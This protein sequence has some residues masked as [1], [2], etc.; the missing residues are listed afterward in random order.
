MTDTGLPK[1][2]LVFYMQADP[3][4]LAKRG[5]Y[6]EERYEKI[7]FQK[8]VKQHF[9]EIFESQDNVE[10]INALYSEEDIYRYIKQKV[11]TSLTVSSRDSI[12]K[13]W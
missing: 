6:G 7:E 11:E 3:E 12:E 1:P 4:I 8:K 13:M 10:F 2:D 9:E 5:N